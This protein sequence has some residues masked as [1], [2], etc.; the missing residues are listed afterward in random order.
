MRL[1]HRITAVVLVG[2]VPVIAVEVYNAIALHNARKLEVHQFALRQAELAASEV[3]RIIEG[4]RSLLTAIAQAPSVRALNTELCSPFI[5]NL[6]SELEYVSVLTVADANGQVRCAPSPE[7]LQVNVADRVYFQQSQITRGLVL[8]EYLIGRVS[9]KPALPFALPIFDDSGKHIGAVV[10]S[11]ELNWL[12]EQLL[13]RGIPEGGSVTIADRKGVIIARQPDPKNF[14]GKRIPDA[15]M[16]LLGEAAP[17]VID[18]ISQDGTSRVLG[19]I[20]LQGKPQGLYVSSGV[21]TEQ[22]YL[23][24]NA[25]VWRQA[26]ITLLAVLTSMGAAFLLGRHFIIKPLER[27]LSTVHRWQEGDLDA[28][29]GL[30]EGQGEAGKLGQEFDRTID[31]L[32]KRQDAVNVLLRELAHRSKNQLALMTG[33]ANQLAKGHKTVATYREALVDRL[34]ALSASQDLLLQGEG[35]SVSLKALLQAQLRS[36]DLQNPNRITLAGPPLMLSSEN[37]RT[38]GMAIH[39]LATNASK[40][41]ALS[42]GMGGVEIFWTD[43]EDNRG[44]MEIKWAENGGPVVNEPNKTGFGRTLI[45]KIVP[46][47]LNGEAKLFY[48]AKGLSWVLTFRPDTDQGPDTKT[49]NPGGESVAHE[50][51]I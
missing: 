17:G 14:V 20:P 11:L 31:Q 33:L 47:Q 29:T 46:M 37:A 4:M 7:Q 27:L 28:R 12:S 1:V 25:A 6:L 8:G 43:P 35:R 49:R 24:V 3:D 23:T 34:L 10:T 19:Y 51:G 48:L 39:E 26:L 44:S 15:Y 36:F 30:S 45:E 38:L 16:H 42:N 18:V 13:K 22:S 32:A 2:L 41:G 21:S 5:R 40:Y 9:K 50:R